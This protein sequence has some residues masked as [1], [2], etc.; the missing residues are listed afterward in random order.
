MRR[1]DLEHV[2]F[3]AAQI[4]NEVEFVVIGSQAILGTEPNPPAAMQ[5]SMEADLYPR[6]APEKAAEIDGS[7]GDGS[8]FHRT[9]GYYAHGVGPETAKAPS[10]WEERLVVIEIAP[11]AGSTQTAT[12]LCL[13]AHDLVLAKCAR[14]EDR[15][16]QFAADALDAGLVGSLCCWSGRGT[17]RSSRTARSRSARC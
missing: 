13:D 5:R 3:A 17:C 8:Q 1:V 14:G 11:R 16:W 15:D 2:V 10:G 6:E 9:F 4:S 7:L 12:A